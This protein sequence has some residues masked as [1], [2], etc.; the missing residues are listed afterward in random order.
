MNGFASC[1]KRESFGT[2]KQQRHAHTM[3]AILTMWTTLFIVAAP[4]AKAAD[5]DA[6]AKSVRVVLIGASIGQAW[7]LPDLP[8]RTRSVGYEFEALQAWQYDKSDVLDELLMRPKRKLHFTRTYLK[9]FFKPNPQPADVVVIKECSAYFPGD[10]S[11]QGQ[12]ALLER[13]V[14]V[15]RGRNI[16]VILATTAP[17]TKRRASLDSGKQESLLAFNDWLRQYAKQN[18]FV[19]LDLE[20][21][22]REDSRER[23]L[24]DEFA[25]EDGA[26]LNRKAYDLLDRQMSEAVCAAKPVGGCSRTGTSSDRSESQLRK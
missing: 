13:W 10:I 26:H 3:A 16:E 4:I 6:P 22:L 1:L 15:I 2:D 25:T 18:G 17:V 9:G 12:R 11:T 19:L 14:Q 7:K 20:A 23:Y 21:T 24:R 5:T 8:T